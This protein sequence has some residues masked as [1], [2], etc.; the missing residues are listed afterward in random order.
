MS[1]ILA[2]SWNSHALRYVLAETQKRGAVRILNAGEKPLTPS[3]DGD[4]DAES[5]TVS[6]QLR[7]T[8]AELKA[9]RA[10]LILCVSRG[11]VDAATFTV[12]PATDAELPTLVQHM[13]QRQLTGLGDDATIDFIDFPAL[14]DGSRQVSAMAMAPA[15]EQQIREM[16]DAAGCAST[17]AIVVTHPLRTFAPPHP[18][19]DRSATLIVSKGLQSAHI[20]VVQQQRPVLSRTL[21][22]APGSGRDAE[23]QFIAAEIQRTVL[24]IGGQLE[25]GVDITDAVLVGSTLETQPLADSL[26]GRIDATVTQTSAGDLVEGGVAEAAQG[27]Y[28]PL[29]AAV[30]DEA[31]GSAAAIDF[32]NPKRPPTSSGK[33]DRLILA[34]VAAVMI[35]GAGAYYVY[36]MFDEWNHRIED[37]EEQLAQLDEQ[38]SSTASMRRQALGVGRWERSRMNWLDELRDI[39]IRM[40]S[41]PELTVGQFAATPTGSGFTVAFKG[42]SQ[43]PEAHRAMELGIQDRYHT[44]RT[45]S[46]RENRVGDKVFWNF[47]TTL[48]IRKRDKKDYTAHQALSSRRRS[49]AGA[50]PPAENTPPSATGDDAADGTSAEAPAEPENE[51]PQQN[52]GGSES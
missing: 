48:Q 32:L 44:T 42:T 39:T 12:P 31:R 7:E 1:R 15:E 47:T 4:N 33:R 17:S 38:V 27:A 45:P 36:S 35:C 10:S 21:R 49:A 3:P 50:D 30:L 18:E 11:S 6:Q 8:V 23:A 46:F 28:A 41:S 16:A 37:L 29:I 13:A 24:T 51:K 26:K 52:T 2:V 5:P 9:S 14:D 40:P 20:L 25:R 43:T 22:L 34:G 19:G